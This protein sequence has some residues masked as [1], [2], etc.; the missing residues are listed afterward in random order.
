MDAFKLKIPQKTIRCDVYNA[1]YHNI[2]KN[3]DKPRKINPPF[4]FLVISTPHYSIFYN[5]LE[6]THNSQTV[7]NV[8]SRD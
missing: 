3:C 2:E 6:Q 7:Y 5:I 1:F 4:I 8:A